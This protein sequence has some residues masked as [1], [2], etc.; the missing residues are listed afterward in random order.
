[1]SVRQLQRHFPGWDEAAGARGGAAGASGRPL[2]SVSCTVPL[3]VMCAASGDR[4]C[5]RPQCAEQS[6]ATGEWRASGAERKEKR[7]KE[8]SGPRNDTNN[9]K[10]GPSGQRQPQADATATAT[11]RART[12]PAHLISLCC[13]A[14]NSYLRIR[15]R[16]PVCLSA[17]SL[18]VF[19][20]PCACRSAG[21]ESLVPRHFARLSCLQR[22]RGFLADNQRMRLLTLLML[23]GIAIFIVS[24]SWTRERATP[25]HSSFPRIRTSLPLPAAAP[26]V[27]PPT[28]CGFPLSQV[29]TVPP[30][31][32]SVPYSIGHMDVTSR[33]RLRGWLCV[34]SVPAESLWLHIVANGEPTGICF[35]RVENREDVIRN[36]HVCTGA[37]SQAQ[38]T[39]R[40][41]AGVMAAESRPDSAD[42]QVIQTGFTI[43]LPYAQRLPP[44][45]S[46]SLEILI[47]PPAGSSPGSVLRLPFPDNPVQVEAA[48]VDVSHMSLAQHR[49]PL[50]LRVS[51]KEPQRLNILMTGL[52][53]DFT[54]GPLSIMRFAIMM[55]R[56]GFRMRWINVDGAGLQRRDLMLHMKKYAILHTFETE[57]EYI[58]DAYQQAE[59]A[60]SPNDVFMATLYFTA[61]MAHAT[62]KLLRNKNFIYF[63][64]DYEVTN[65]LQRCAQP[66]CRSIRAPCVDLCLCVC[67]RACVC[68]PYCMQPIF[69]AHDANW[70]EASES[71]RLPHFPIFS[72]VFLQRHFVAM[73]ESIYA[74]CSSAE[75]CSRIGFYAQPAIKPHSKLDERNFPVGR[76]HKLIAYARKHADRNAFDLTI[77]ALS[78][79]VQRGVFGQPGEWSHAQDN[80]R[81]HTKG[82]SP[83]GT[84]K[85]LQRVHYA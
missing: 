39:A 80:T 43:D 63:I 14:S 77:L 1:M 9:N 30:P 26:V 51:D 73:K 23:A 33:S 44:S 12:P 59:I 13:V 42:A 38:A 46:V 37:Q 68:V 5:L 25:K 85:L 34:P 27:D 11:I 2:L 35:R 7:R 18:S 41:K 78:E 81:Q 29:S 24:G 67:A 62:Q 54:G 3:C 71:Y 36:V 15:L 32:S 72:T 49:R 65:K 45:A 75:E 28:L 8:G 19:V 76:V 74:H 53:T 47:A 6:R 17:A 58:H 64:Q 60:T 61:Q 57:I 55:A 79:A 84:S 56:A 4:P 83:T 66:A 50:P 21:M 48:S 69:F 10:R 40:A 70:L 20:C 52:G 22:A 16:V 82:H 31:G